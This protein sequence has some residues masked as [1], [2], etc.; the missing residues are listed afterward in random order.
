[1]KRIECSL[2]AL[3]VMALYGLS[4]C[5][6]SGHDHDHAHDGNGHHDGGDHHHDGDGADHDHDH[7]HDGSDHDHDHDHIVAGPN[8]GRV[9]TDLEPHVEFFVTE[10]RK[11]Q[12]TVVDDDLQSLAPS[13]QEIN[14][15]AGERTDP[16]FLRFTVEGQVFVSDQ[17]LPEGNNFPVVVQYKAKADAELVRAQFNVDL[18]DCPTCP[19]LEYACT[20]DH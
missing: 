20:C 3:S 4:A 7:E 19:N 9:L 2:I 11:V 10:D 15:I 8:G 17:P 6:R 18:R 16:T 5:D 13:G 12:F 14:V 1:M